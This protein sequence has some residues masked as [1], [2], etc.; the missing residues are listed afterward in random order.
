[1]VMTLYSVSG[2]IS[3]KFSAVYFSQAQVEQASITNFFTISPEDMFVI[4]CSAQ[5]VFLSE[6]Y[7]FIF[8]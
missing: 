8:N 5:R 7:M 4:R 6:K 1:M 2:L 3:L